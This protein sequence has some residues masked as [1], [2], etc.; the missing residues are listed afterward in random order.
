M[1]RVLF[2][3]PKSGSGKTLISC[4]I[5]RA[6]I[7]NGKK[8]SAFKCGPDYIDPMFHR[9]IGA[10][11]G[12]LDTYFCDK[13]TVKY[14]LSE[15]ADGSD[16][17]LI[18]GVMGY[19]D[20]LG[21]ISVEASAY[22]IARVTKTPVILIVD[23]KGA[24]V[25]AVA[26]IKGFVEYKE[27]SYIK[28][29]ILNRI[30]PMLYSGIKQ[31]IENEMDIRVLG[32][33]PEIKEIC[34][35]SRHLGLIMPQEIDSIKEKMNTLAD[36]ISQTVDLNGIKELGEKAENIEISSIDIPTAT[37]KVRIGVAF[38]E[39]FCFYYQENLR[40]IEKMGGEIIYFSPLKDGKLPKELN[41]II[42]G[43][44]YPELFAK[45]LSANKSMLESIKNAL[46][47][48]IPCIAE[49]GGFMYL[50]NSIEDKDGTVYP[51]VGYLNGSGFKTSKL[52]RF[53]YITLETNEDTIFGETGTEMKGHEF[54]Y[55]DS[56]ENGIAC[57]A[58]KPN[59]NRSWKCVY[60]DENIFAG[61]PHLYFY[62]NVK[63][64]F[65]FIE[66]CGEYSED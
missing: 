4:G 32:Y 28:G 38:D 30:S 36:V 45:E 3:A 52:T 29:V 33:V 31:L 49:C 60:A 16:I 19:Y 39:A 46:E 37:K 24:S 64:V 22:D 14:L 40:L 10:K 58:V 8:V 62:S 34:L 57:T 13:N 65:K 43:G 1:N 21:G 7:N 59:R 12:N 35:E 63:A 41:G 11:S 48:K 20:G 47:N 17:T 54:H 6:F 42:F 50:Q 23:C 15:G 55:W 66:K 44:G 5:M 2:A 51:M 18:E 9:V 53:G 25:S 27:E 61:F 56:T 26:Q